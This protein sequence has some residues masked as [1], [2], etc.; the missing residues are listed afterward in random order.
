MQPDKADGE[1]VLL[2][3]DSIRFG[4]FWRVHVRQG[5]V[6]RVQKIRMMDHNEDTHGVLAQWVLAGQKT[7]MGFI[8]DAWQADRPEEPS[9]HLTIL[10]NER[11]LGDGY[12]TPRIRFQQGFFERDISIEADDGWTFHAR[13]NAPWL[14]ETFRQFTSGGMVDSF[15]VDFVERLIAAVRSYRPQWL[16]ETFTSVKGER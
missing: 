7:T 10:V 1:R 15:P 5:A 6:L 16:V 4:W 14:R 13:Y 12:A 11:L 9:K 2:L 8:F 3:W